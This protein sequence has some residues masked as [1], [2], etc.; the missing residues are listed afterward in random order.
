MSEFRTIHGRNGLAAHQL[1][2]NGSPTG[3]WR[4][5]HKG[6]LLCECPSEAHAAYLISALGNLTIEQWAN[7]NGQALDILEAA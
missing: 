6:S 5:E 1:G 4:V 3:G 2:R 7:A